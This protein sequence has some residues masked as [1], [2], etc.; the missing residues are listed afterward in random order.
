MVFDRKVIED[1]GYPLITP[2]IVLNADDFG[3]VSPVLE[4]TV[5]PGDLVIEVTPKE[6]AS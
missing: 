4:G 2:V 6:A 1:A 3:G 5:K